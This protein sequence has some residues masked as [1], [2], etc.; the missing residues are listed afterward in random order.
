[1]YWDL[2]SPEQEQALGIAW[3][4]W[5]FK[6]NECLKEAAKHPSPTYYQ[7]VASLMLRQQKSDEAIATKAIALD[8]SDPWSYD[9]MS[10]AL[11]F[12]GRPSDGRGYIDTAM[13]VEPGRIPWRSYDAGLAYFAQGTIRR[14]G[15]FTR[16]DRY[17][18]H[19]TLGQFLWDNCANGSVRAS[20]TR[21][22]HRRR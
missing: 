12:N 17:A 22:R 21:W 15:G 13:R 11:T 19:G 16:K 14:G 1:M 3:D 20:R 7:I 2:H 5:L 10:Q 9:E 4:D 6:L 18:T 8:A